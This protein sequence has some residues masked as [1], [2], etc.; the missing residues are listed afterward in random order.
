M[1]VHIASCMRRRHWSVHS[2]PSLPS[3]NDYQTANEEGLQRVRVFGNKKNET[4]ENLFHLKVVLDVGLLRRL[5]NSPL[6]FIVRATSVCRNHKRSSF[7]PPADIFT[8]K[9]L[10]YQRLWEARPR[11][12]SVKEPPWGLGEW[13][14]RYCSG[15][16]M[17]WG[18]GARGSD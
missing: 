9:N 18:P 2:F 4:R 14:A 13:G 11:T 8:T 5:L 17:P 15:D 10:I 6:L 3:T 16:R 12:H 7:L 1:S